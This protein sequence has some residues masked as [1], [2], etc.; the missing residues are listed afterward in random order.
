METDKSREREYFSKMSMSELNS[1]MDKHNLHS[2][3]LLWWD[4]EQWATL[5]EYE[6]AVRQG[7]IDRLSRCVTL[8]RRETPNFIGES[9]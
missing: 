4:E 6:E 7:H 8:K 3:F 9:V 5:E 2:H 1:F